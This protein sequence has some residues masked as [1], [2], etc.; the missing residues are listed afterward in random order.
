VAKFTKH[1]GHIAE[2]VGGAVTMFGAATG[3]PEIVAGGGL[4]MAGGGLA[5]ASAGAYR[6][7]RK[8]DP[9]KVMHHAKAGHKHH[10][11]FL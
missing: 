9:E 6:G 7:I 5:Q 8:G 4:L 1:A 3:Q 11:H 10:K 2:D